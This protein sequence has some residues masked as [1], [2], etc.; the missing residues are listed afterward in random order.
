MATHA[1]DLSGFSSE[2]ADSEHVLSRLSDAYL[3]EF[4]DYPP[5]H[6][7]PAE[8]AI[9]LVR[10]ALKSGEKLEP[11]PFAGSGCNCS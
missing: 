7:M 1:S 11:E 5:V 6:R 2:N 3:A 4:G 9:E 10:A 8:L